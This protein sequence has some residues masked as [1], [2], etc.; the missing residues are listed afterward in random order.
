LPV[1]FHCPG[2]NTFC[3][4]KNPT[5]PMEQVTYLLCRSS[6]VN[7]SNNYSSLFTNMFGLHKYLESIISIEITRFF[8]MPRRRGYDAFFIVLKKIC[9]HDL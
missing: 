5:L 2:K 9:F 8:G 4:G 1:F 3:H 6:D 7:L